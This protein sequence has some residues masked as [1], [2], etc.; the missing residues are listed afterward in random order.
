MD[1]S[2]IKKKITTPD[3]LLCRTWSIVEA[4]IGIQ[5][6]K[7]FLFLNKK[8]LPSHPIIP[9]LLEVDE[10]WHH[11]ILDTRQYYIDSMAIFGYYLHHYPYFGARGDEDLQHLNIAFEE[12][13]K[14]YELEF[15]SRMISIWSPPE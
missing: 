4:E 7:N 8:Y 12:S 5:Y 3:P 13:Q 15:G 10:I 14:L 6:Y 2:L 1:F 11:H 9:P